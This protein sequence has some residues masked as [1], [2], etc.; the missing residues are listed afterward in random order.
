LNE[1][2]NTS[3]WEDFNYGECFIEVGNKYNKEINL[4][5]FFPNPAK[6]VIYIDIADEIK[7]VTVFDINGNIVLV[8]NYHCAEINIG[9]F[10]SGSYIISIETDKG[11]FNKT[12]IKK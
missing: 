10:K 11:N 4:F 8:K 3:I 9:N 12:I 1:Y 6:D 2:Q 7:S 5:N